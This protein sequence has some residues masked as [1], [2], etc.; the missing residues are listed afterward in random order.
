VYA[1]EPFI[2]GP[3]SYEALAELL[4]AAWPESPAS[5]SYY[6]RTDRQRGPDAPR[7]AVV[8]DPA[9]YQRLVGA[10]EWG[11]HLW[12]RDGAHFL[13]TAAVHPEHRRRGLGERLLHHALSALPTGCQG[14]VETWTTEDRPE[15]LTFLE[16]RGF[17]LRLRSQQSELDLERFD[18]ERFVRMVRTL[19]QGGLRIRSLA[20]G[21][22]DDETLLH[23]LHAL[24]AEAIR[25]A[26]GG[27]RYEPEPFE[28]WRAMYQDNPDF[29][30]EGHLVAL[31]G[32]RVVGM[33]QLWAS[34]ATP[35]I[36]YTG[37]TGV[38]RSHRRRGIATALKLRSLGWARSLRS[39]DGRRPVVRTGNADTNP[40]LA[41]NLRLGF[42]PRPAV[43]VLERRLG[44]PEEP[45]V[46]N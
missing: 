29:L 35:A 27:D 20:A 5:A 18:P 22:T 21:G 15:A 23:G 8:R 3:F 34:L 12:L 46:S 6:E 17:R 33:T 32:P 19:E 41:L 2:P 1:L 11:S 31:D 9:A 13:V 36:V 24:N 28:R 25:D 4:T 39:A 10:V 40:M 30:P 43:M 45:P 42:K 7:R 16:R 44:G 14:S 38:A 26:P 37:F